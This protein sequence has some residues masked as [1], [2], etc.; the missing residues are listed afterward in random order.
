MAALT[1]RDPAAAVAMLREQGIT[2]TD[3]E[4]GGFISPRNTYRTRLRLSGA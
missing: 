1:V 2:V 4:Q 3:A